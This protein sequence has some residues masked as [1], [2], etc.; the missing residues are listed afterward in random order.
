[1]DTLSPWTSTIRR[2]SLSLRNSLDTG[3]S[4]LSFNDWAS[5][6]LATEC[7]EA[8]ELV[9]KVIVALRDSDCSSE[10]HQTLI[11]QLSSL[12]EVL[13]SCESLEL[14]QLPFELVSE[15]EQA[16]IFC[17]TRINSWLEDI[18]RRQPRGSVPSGINGVNGR[19]LLR[20]D[21]CDKDDLSEFGADLTMDGMYIQGLMLQADM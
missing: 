6:S 19:K 10:D 8:S 1:M 16:V 4:S 7:L 17:Q 14:E 13:L 15:L 9:A 18:E 11:T 12:G 3:R 5:S 2:G 21:T 20:W